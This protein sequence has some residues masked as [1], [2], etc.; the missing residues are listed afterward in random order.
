MDIFSYRNASDPDIVMLDKK[1][2]LSPEEIKEPFSSSPQDNS[3]LSPNV[4]PHLQSSSSTSSLST[5]GSVSSCPVAGGTL[6][7]RERSIS[8]Y[9]NP[10]LDTHNLSRP[11]SSND[12]TTINSTLTS[13]I[14]GFG[15]HQSL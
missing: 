6:N 11:N 8:V 5:C 7:G 15:S 4:S 9:R 14:D 12:I 10:F 1:D 3:R 2:E 13:C